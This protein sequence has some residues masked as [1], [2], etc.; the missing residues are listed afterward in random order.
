M[1]LLARVA[2]FLEDVDGD[3]QVS[4]YTDDVPIRTVRFPS[5]WELSAARAIS[6]VRLLRQMGIAETKMQAVGHGANRPIAS[7]S[8]AIGRSINR[9]VTIDVTPRPGPS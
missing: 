8:H 9:R 2:T 1:E 6:V 7:N 5:N 3:I 4:G